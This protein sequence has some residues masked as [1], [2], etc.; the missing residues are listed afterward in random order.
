MNRKKWSMKWAATFQKLS[1]YIMWHSNKSTFAI[2]FLLLKENNT[3]TKHILWGVLPKIC[4]RFKPTNTTVIP[5]GLK[6][7]RNPTNPHILHVVTCS[8]FHSD[9]SA[10]IRI[11]TNQ[12]YS[13]TKWSMRLVKRFPG[14]DAIAK[15]RYRGLHYGST[16][17]ARSENY[18]APPLLTWI[19]LRPSMDK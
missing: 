18:Q 3:E 14:F 13:N 17:S 2:L 10:T 9:S 1:F 11:I 7:R 8:K 16:N 5:W 19:D 15:I 4:I 12:F 6:V